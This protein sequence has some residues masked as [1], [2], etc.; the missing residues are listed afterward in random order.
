[1]EFN[2]QNRNKRVVG[3]E[4][5]TALVYYQTIIQLEIWVRLGVEGD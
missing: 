1:M 3:I 4:P 2:L 5:D